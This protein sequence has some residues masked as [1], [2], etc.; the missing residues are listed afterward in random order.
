MTAL[1]LAVVAPAA[2][3]GWTTTRL[4][5]GPGELFLLGVDCPTTS[6]CAAVGTQNLIAT[7]TDPSGG[8]AAWHTVYAG[9]GRF[10]DSVTGASVIS[11]RQVQG[12]SCPS[13]RLCVAVTTLGQIYASTDPTGPASAWSV[14]ELKPSGSNIHLYGVSCPTESL[15]VAVSGR[16]T[17]RGKVL[18]STDPTGG[19]AAWQEADL[20][21]QF[22]LRAVSCSSATL[23]VAAGANGELVASTDP[24]G[25][26]GAWTSLGPLGGSLLQSIDCAAGV[27]LA[28]NA[29]GNLLAAGEPT[30]PGSWRT[31]SSG[32]SVQ[33]TGTACASAGACLA[34]DNNGDVVV[35]TEPTAPQPHWRLTNVRP[36]SEGAEEPGSVDANGLFGASCPSVELCVLV[37]SRGTILTSAEPFVPAATPKPPPG[38]TKSSGKRRRGPLRPHSRIA[39]L[40]FFAFEKDAGASGPRRTKMRIRFYAR[41]P[42]RRFECRLDRQRFRTC[43]SPRRYAAIGRGIHAVRVRAVGRTGLRGPAATE[44]FYVGRVCRGGTCLPGAAP[45]PRGPGWKFG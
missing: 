21:E 20:G 3:A 33:V 9:E 11:G 6:F 41:G 32:A 4:P 10:E 7:S 35:S 38:G 28:G 17:N 43:R 5:G 34:V 23:C 14:A 25:G 45:L 8:P 39:R 26:P 12:V 29:G 1:V 27:C 15:C 13:S 36:Y 16:R 44:R 19:V 31:A 42:V 37:G 40:D 30:R 22:D 24:T 18:T 2:A